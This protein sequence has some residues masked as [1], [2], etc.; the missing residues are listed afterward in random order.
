MSVTTETVLTDSIY[1]C[2]YTN[3]NIPAQQQS[4]IN[5]FSSLTGMASFLWCLNHGFPSMQWS[6]WQCSKDR[7]WKNFTALS[8]LVLYIWINPLL[9]LKHGWTSLMYPS[10]TAHSVSHHAAISRAQS[11]V[12]FAK[13]WEECVLS[14]ESFTDSFNHSF[15]GPHNSQ[16]QP[17]WGRRGAEAHHWGN[18]SNV[19]CP[20]GR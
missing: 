7:S 20:E 3:W 9:S 14:F 2:C 15:D 1:I 6:E 4:I 12:G 10:Q 8:F 18:W 13:E 11:R 5:N 16:W 17:E 19:P